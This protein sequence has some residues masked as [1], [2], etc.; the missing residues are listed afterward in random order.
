MMKIENLLAEE[1]VDDALKVAKPGD[2]DLLL[3]KG[4]SLMGYEG[5]IGG[6][7]ERIFNG[8]FF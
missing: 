8:C 5:E 1:R 4:I 3:E 2:I 7:A 6:K